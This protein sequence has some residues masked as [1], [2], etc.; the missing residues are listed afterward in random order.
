VIVNVLCCSGKDSPNTLRNCHVNAKL[1][2][3]ENGTRVGCGVIRKQVFI[4]N[5]KKKLLF[6]QTTN[7]TSSGAASNVTV[8]AIRDDEV[9]YFGRAKNLE[10]SLTSYL[11]NYPVGTNCNFTNGCGVHLHEGFSC[12]N[13]TSQG[14]H[15]WNVTI[16]PTDPWLYAMYHKTDAYG[17]AY[18]TGCVKTGVDGPDAFAGRAFILHSDNGT[19][20][21][22]GILQRS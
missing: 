18:F 14:P 15:L 3:S 21:S 13:R 6:T 7:L 22:C 12:F 9:C 5:N 11:N 17:N 8:F 2:H 20:V 10:V 16:F 4:R 19:R 1:V